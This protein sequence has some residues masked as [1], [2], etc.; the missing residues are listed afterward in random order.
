MNTILYIRS[1]I[2]HMKDTDNGVYIHWIPGHKGFEGNELADLL[3]KEAK[4]KMENS[5]TDFYEVTEDD[6]R[7]QIERIGYKT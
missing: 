5:K 1:M 2:A 6:M 3:A 7:S 4:N